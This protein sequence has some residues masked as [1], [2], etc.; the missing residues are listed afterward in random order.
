[1]D[2]NEYSAFLEQRA[3][4]FRSIAAKTKGAM[5]PEDLHGEA[6]VAAEYHTAKRGFPINWQDPEDQ[7][8]ILATLTVDHV[9]K[10]KEERRC[11]ISADACVENDDGNAIT[12]IDLLQT[13]DAPDP[14]ELLEKKEEAETE[15]VRRMREDE[16]LETYSQSV[17]YNVVLWHFDNIR[18]KLAAYLVIDRG[19]LRNRIDRAASILK[20]QPSLF[21]RIE[22]ITS[23]FWPLRGQE[24]YRE[25]RQHLAGD[26]W[27]W[28]F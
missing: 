6:W 27:R 21:D 25:V 18:C 9:W 16:I 2:W 11:T 4:D 13:D 12:M 8:L 15:R 28:D 10:L 17:A 5:T 1:M 3:K 20:V 19:T 14:L 7:K 23:S 26:Q 24:S 22:R